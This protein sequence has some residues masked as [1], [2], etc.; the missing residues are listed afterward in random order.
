MSVKRKNA[1]VKSGHKYSDVPTQSTKGTTEISIFRFEVKEGDQKLR[2][3]GM[4]SGLSRHTLTHCIYTLNHEWVCVKYLDVANWI[5]A[6]LGD[7][8]SILW[9]F[10]AIFKI[11]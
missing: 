4:M 2:K 3:Y 8:S 6:T 9:D 11:L 5:I 1:W 7:I 10:V